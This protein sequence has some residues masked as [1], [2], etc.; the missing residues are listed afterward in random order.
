M[1]IKMYKPY[2]LFTLVLLFISGCSL[3]RTQKPVHPDS[4][5]LYEQITESNIPWVTVAASVEGR[6]ILLYET[7]TG[8]NT[9]LIFG[10]FHGNE[11]LG[12]KLVLEFAE[13]LHAN[14]PENAKVILV[15]LVNPD[16]LLLNT[17][18]NKNRTDINRNFP[19]ENWGDSTR[20]F[21]LMPGSAPASE[22]ETKAVI[23]LVKRYNPDKIITVHTPLEVVN[24]DG[25]AEAL[26]DTM[27]EIT[28]YP[29]RSDIGYPTPGSFGTYAGREMGKPVIT[30]ELPAKPFDELWEKNRDALIAAVHFK[31][32]GN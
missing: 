22:P 23:E 18:T 9:T 8:E 10:G 4:Y 20:G 11:R 24:Y 19:T 25:P 14:P 28:G 15:P 2:I 17:R 1:R 32:S 26:A 12:I 6:E 16:G 21:I 29:A 5:E 30:L 27:A 31:I 3:F 7:G 13:Y